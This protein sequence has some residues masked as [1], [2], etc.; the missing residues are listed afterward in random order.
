MA[1]QCCVSQNVPY[2]LYQHNAPIPYRNPLLNFLQHIND[3][4]PGRYVAL[5]AS[6]ALA[7]SHHTK[8]YIKKLANRD[9]GVLY[10]AVDDCA[11]LL[12]YLSRAVAV[13]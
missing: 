8:E 5:H 3:Q 10:P 2:I 1:A 7:T 4:G 12:P 11:S 13:P 9:V 6:Q